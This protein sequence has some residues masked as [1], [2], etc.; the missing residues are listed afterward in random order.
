MAWILFGGRK[1]GDVGETVIFGGRL[2]GP[3]E[4][5]MRVVLNKSL[6][7][8]ISVQV[9]GVPGQSDLVLLKGVVLEALHNQFDLDST[10]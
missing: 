5:L 4:A 8:I 6:H 9:E 1:L 3:S 7:L 10:V 2:D